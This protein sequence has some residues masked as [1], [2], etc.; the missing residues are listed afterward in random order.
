VRD[1]LDDLGVRQPSPAGPAEF[2][3]GAL[4]AAERGL[5][6]EFRNRTRARLGPPPTAL[7]SRRNALRID[8]QQPP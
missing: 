5:A 4:A 8:P 2:R 1:R 6:Y 3:V 7:A